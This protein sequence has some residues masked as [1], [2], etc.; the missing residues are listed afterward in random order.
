MNAA[1]RATMPSITRRAQI[2]FARFAAELRVSYRPATA[3]EARLVND[4]IGL[5]LDAARAS[6][7][8]GP[9]AALLL[10]LVCLSWVPAY[11]VALWLTIFLGSSIGCGVTFELLTRRLGSS[12]ADIGRRARAFTWLS[13]V[14][15]VGW[16][17]MGLLLWAPDIPMDH[18]VVGLA[19]AASLTAWTAI[20]SYHFATGVAGFPLYLF[21]LTLGS[22]VS[23][24]YTNLAIVSAY[25]LLM[26]NLFSSNYF[27]R[28][29]MLLLEH[30]RVELIASLK[31]A[32]EQSDRARERAEAA[33]RAKSAFLANMS[34]ELRTPLNAILGFSEIIHTKALGNAAIEQYAEYGGYIHGSGRHLLALINDILELS[35][36]EA[37]KLVL[38]ETLV[39]L[40]RLM[41]ESI[42][43]QSGR[44]QSVGLSLGSEIDASFPLVW[45]DERA[46]RQILDNLLSNA[47]KFTPPGGRVECFAHLR[48]DGSLAFGV[49]DTGVGIAPEDHARVFASFGQSRH[50][51]VVADKGT[52][53]GLPIVKGL[54]TA[55]KGRVELQSAP[56]E[57]TRLTIVLPSERARA[58]LRAAS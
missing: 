3:A 26:V 34:H 41:H 40:G 43:A 31:G 15:T 36:I 11:K 58:S 30:E 33:S 52:G 50:D 12:T 57:G 49:S 48:S 14:Q 39:D 17:S 22:L 13:F 25:W 2:A 28:K 20:A 10:G 9:L 44:A 21:I 38:N 42:Q 7:I 54:I 45:A 1:V 56:G 53:L 35:K 55:H 4:Q 8:I 27:T 46:M 16:C 51:A 6:S 37:G 29:K 5:A 19:L 24:R 18:I 32:K 47:V 23:A